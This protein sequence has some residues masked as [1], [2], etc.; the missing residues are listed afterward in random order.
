MKLEYYEALND[1]DRRMVSVTRDAGKVSRMHTYGITDYS[2][3]SHTYNMMQMLIAFYPLPQIP[4]AL[5]NAV[6]AHDV[7]EVLLGDIPSP[8]KAIGDL[9]YEFHQAEAQVFEELYYYNP[10]ET[11]NPNEKMWLRALDLI[12]LYLWIL[13]EIGSGNRSHKLKCILRNISVVLMN[14]SMP[15]VLAPFRDN[16]IEEGWE[17]VVPEKEIYG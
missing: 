14:A 7:P 6:M 11:L 3:A 4:Q 9:G 13:E 16:L 17:G 5:T 1:P 2:V 8:A 10:L 15:N 12:E